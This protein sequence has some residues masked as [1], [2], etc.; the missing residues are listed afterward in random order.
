MKV[1]AKRK[2]IAI[3]MVMEGKLVLKPLFLELAL[4]IA[5]DFRSSLIINEPNISI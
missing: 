5:L 4:I 2:E 1:L 3:A